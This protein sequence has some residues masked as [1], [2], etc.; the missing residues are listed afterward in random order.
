MQD[1]LK[2]VAA[3][4]KKCGIDGIQTPP[5]LLLAVSGGIDSMVMLYALKALSSGTG[6][7]DLNLRFN[8]SVITVNHNLRKA[9]ETEGDALFVQNQCR[10]LKIPCTLKT[11]APGE[12]AA[13]ASQ[14]GGGIE[15]A[16][17]F[18]RYKLFE[19]EAK[20]RFCDF[21]CLAHN[22]DDQLETLLQRFFQGASAGI[23]GQAAA[24]IAKRRGLFCRPLLDIPRSAIQAYA[25][26]HGIPFR[27]DSTNRNT[28]YFRNNLRR[29]VVP[30]L[31]EHVRGWDT[32]VLSGAQKAAE[33]AAFIEKLASAVLWEPCVLTGCV[34]TGKERVKRHTAGT[35]A[36][37]TVRTDASAFFNAG[38]PV[39]IRALYNAAHKV[40]A[41]W[42]LPYALFRDCASGQSRVKGCGIEFIRTKRFL[43]VNNIRTKPEPDTINQG[44]CIQIDAPGTYDFPLGYFEVVYASDLQVQKKANCA[45]NKYGE[46]CMGPFCLPVRLRSRKPGDRIKTAAGTHKTLKKIWNEWN[47]EP[48]HTSLIPVIEYGQNPVC[49][50]GA[51][52]GYPDWYVKD[53]AGDFSGVFFIF[54]SAGITAGI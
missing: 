20:A 36:V 27:E 16:A 34:L 10:L 44:Y 31:N 12:I 49:I 51:P 40:S 28:A 29:R 9:C 5:S 52:L 15:E 54:K 7:T 22:R 32:A 30:F 14:R 23:S 35:Q 11:V 17:R 8:L 43:Y 45:D 2:K 25:E 6:N 39:R 47:I 19:N 37:F 46:V 48:H 13:A 53:C 3:G 4:L 50:W 41:A 42:R 26:K 21:V 33:E 24:G 1:F 18:V 38:F